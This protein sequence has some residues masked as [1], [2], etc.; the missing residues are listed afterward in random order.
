[1]N[2]QVTISFIK[3]NYLQKLY[4]IYMHTEFNAVKGNEKTV[5]KFLEFIFILMKNLKE[6]IVVE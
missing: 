6:M 1:M 4:E 3:K 2:P 5:N